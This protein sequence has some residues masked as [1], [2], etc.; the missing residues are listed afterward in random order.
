MIAVG[1]RIFDVVGGRVD[2][3]TGIIPR[4]GLNPRILVDGAEQL[5]LFVTNVD[6]MFRQQGHCRHVS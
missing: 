1:D 3:D 4:P 6:G 5:E 2:E